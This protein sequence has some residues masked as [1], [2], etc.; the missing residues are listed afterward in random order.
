MI[1]SSLPDAVQQL[2]TGQVIAYAT[3][4]VF[5][6]GC[7]PDNEQ[8]VMRLLDI[9]Q[10]PMAKGLILVAAN[11][12]QLRPYLD[13]TQVP[14]ANMAIALAS[15]PGPFTWVMPAARH[16]PH[17]LTGQFDSLAVRVSAHP[18]VQALC[19]AFDKPIVS[20]SANLTGCP[21]CRTVDE[22]E[23]QL[24]EQV[25]FILAGTVSGATNP[26]QIR[27]VMTGNTL[28]PG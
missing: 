19:Q 9:K 21:P 23:Q 8:A 4:A 15:W 28:R 7:D 2:H 24:K 18:Q 3:E 14:A 10:R 13:T 25:P 12:Q 1:L 22:V 6:L 11:W 20:T 26:S 27:D 5:G 16:T 17:W